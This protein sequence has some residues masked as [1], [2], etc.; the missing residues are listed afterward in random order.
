MNTC[1]DNNIPMSDQL[2][3]SDWLVAQFMTHDCD[4]I[5]ATN[6]YVKQLLKTN[7]VLCGRSISTSNILC[8]DILMIM[9]FLRRFGFTVRGDIF[10][11]G[12]ELS[13]FP[14]SYL[15]LAQGL[16]YLTADR[17]AKLGNVIP[18]CTILTEEGG[19]PVFTVYQY[20]VERVINSSVFRQNSVAIMKQ[21][22]TICPNWILNCYE[23]R[24]EDHGFDVEA[25]ELL[26]YGCRERF[27]PVDNIPYCI[28]DEPYNLCWECLLL[29]LDV[30]SHELAVK[31]SYDLDQ[32]S[33]ES[34]VSINYDLCARLRVRK[35]LEAIGFFELAED[36][37]RVASTTKLLVNYMG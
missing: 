36:R 4:K 37:D 3:F 5:P 32:H 6:Y 16:E 8:N 27:H 2:E 18:K 11:S 17:I 34:G 10:C 14:S 1:N 24:R 19:R 12:N 35:V 22:P 15:S 21:F 13:R 28:D 29:T 9:Y 25:H 20:N 30:P 23:P 7:T 31:I 26:C 33:V